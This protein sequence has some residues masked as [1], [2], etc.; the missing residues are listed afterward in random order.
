MAAFTRLISRVLES[1][2]HVAVRGEQQRSETSE[3]TSH[4]VGLK[5]KR[6]DQ[7][8]SKTDPVIVLDEEENDTEQES[9]PKRSRA[10]LYSLSR[11]DNVPTWVRKLCM[12]WNFVLWEATTSLT[13]TE[14]TV[15]PMV[16]GLDTGATGKPIF[17]VRCTVTDLWYAGPWSGLSW[18]PLSTVAKDVSDGLLSKL[19]CLFVS[20]HN[21]QKPSVPN[22]PTISIIKSLKVSCRYPNHDGAGVLR[23]ESRDLESLQDRSY[24]N[25]SVV[26]YFVKYLERSQSPDIAPRMLFC[27][28][29]FFKKFCEGL[30]GSQNADD[31]VCSRPVLL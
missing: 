4:P 16:N 6:D 17:G 14:L 12:L 8:G 3:K 20:G 29:F 18:L 31:A 19:R 26:D 21:Q 24:V 22:D 30:H 15:R 7:Q 25:D 28:C 13:K 23:I 1:A 5:R 2:Q 27:N 9:D 11:S 10:F